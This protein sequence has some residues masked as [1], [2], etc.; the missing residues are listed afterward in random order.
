MPLNHFDRHGPVH[1]ILAQRA[2]LA[3]DAPRA[4]ET[5]RP[6]TFGARR[7]LRPAPD[8]QALGSGLNRYLAE[9]V[10]ETRLIVE[11]LPQQAGNH[12]ARPA[13]RRFLIELVEF[14]HKPLH[15]NL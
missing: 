3:R 6:V 13:R 10:H 9:F 15:N 7:T 11:R 12:F 5:A 4:T 8:A 14:I 2:R 1:R